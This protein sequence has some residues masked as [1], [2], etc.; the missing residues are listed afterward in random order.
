MPDQETLQS[1]PQE[2]IEKKE[3]LL[4]FEAVGDFSEGA[5]F[6]GGELR[7]KV[8]ISKNVTAIFKTLTGDEVDRINEAIKVDK[9][10]TAAQYNTDVTNLNLCYSL[11]SVGDTHLKPGSEESL[12]YLKTLPAAVL[13]RLSLAYVEFNS[14]VDELFGGEEVLEKAKK[15]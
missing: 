8:F 7:G 9:D 14:R 1:P 10:T 12:E 13:G 15:S 11:I 6:T 2:S 5:L 4:D 3:Y